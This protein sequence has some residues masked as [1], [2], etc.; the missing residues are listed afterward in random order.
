[1]PR[2]LPTYP[3]RAHSSG[4]AR[5]K[6]NGRVV[7]LGKFGSPE[8]HAKFHRVIAEYLG[9][10]V[11]PV[12]DSV[13]V[14]EIAVAEL[15]AQFLKHATERYVKNG[16][17]TSEVRSYKTALRPVY[18]LY[19]G[20]KVSEF[21]PR[22]LMACRQHLIDQG[23]TRKRINQHVVRIRSVFKWGVSREMVPETTWRALQSLQGLRR[24]ELGVSDNQAVAP[25]PP[26]AVEAIRAF[27][28]PPVWTMVQLQLLTGCRPGEAC[29]I[30]TGDIRTDDPAL[31]PDVRGRVWIY[32]PGS[33]KTEHHGRSRLILLGPKA[34]ALLGPWLRPDEPERHLFSPAEAVAFALAKRRQ[35]SKSPRRKTATKRNPNRVPRDFY[36]EH[37]YGV[38]V[39]RA[40][41]KAGVAHWS[42]N[43]LRHSAGTSLRSESGVEVVRTI[44]GHASMSTTEIYAE[45]DLEKAAALIL[46]VG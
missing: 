5:I 35:A 17:P 45:R 12:P 6:L 23:Y 38:A 39:R 30:R 29:D 13:Q 25:A 21:G 7:Y 14:G 4:Q 46:A 34:Q 10:A 19:G 43:Q 8:S 9:A 28:L 18:R 32:R 11:E 22:A 3:S 27:V 37:A 24:G 36:A 40:C 20:V 33:H 31:P 44:L 42:P 1:M 2:R 15:L 26:E 16:A 41:Q